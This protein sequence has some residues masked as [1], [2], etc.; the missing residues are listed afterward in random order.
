MDRKRIGRFLSLG[1]GTQSSVLA[2]MSAHGELPPLDCAI[3]ADTDWEP[4]DVYEHL[5]WLSTAIAAAPHPFPVHKVDNG[6]SLRADATACV[7]QNGV[8]HIVIP[9]HAS[10][11]MYHRQCTDQY[12]VKPIER[13]ARALF[14][15]SRSE[16]VEQWMGISLDEIQRMKAHPKRWLV[17]A[18]PLIDASMTRAD[19]QAWFSA[20]YPDRGALPKSSC[21][22][23]PFH[24]VGAWALVRRRYPVHFAE[25]V[26]IERRM[27]AYAASRDEPRP[28]LH[29]RKRP[30]DQAVP[31]PDLQPMLWDGAD[32]GADE[33]GGFCFS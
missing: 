21:V 33:C 3:F 7:N 23:C 16:Y 6:R 32:D 28:Y 18:W 13:K 24:S 17:T 22:G 10:R 19:C 1:G 27:H 29:S 26:E 12:K 2:L 20:H 8:P 11:G 14:N 4:P 25:C 5:A 9:A 30:L 15:P 31:D